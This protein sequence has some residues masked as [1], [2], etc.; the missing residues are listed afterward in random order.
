MNNEAE[1]KQELTHLEALI[2]MLQ[3]RATGLRKKLGIVSTM[4]TLN[5]ENEDLKFLT[6]VREKYFK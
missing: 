5:S 2:S 3:K 1:I 6:Q 4:P